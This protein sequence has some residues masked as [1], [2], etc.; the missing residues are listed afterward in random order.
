MDQDLADV[1]FLLNNVREKKLRG[2]I[3]QFNV[4]PVRKGCEGK[5]VFVGVI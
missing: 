5:K 2:V 1:Q 3:I 4:S